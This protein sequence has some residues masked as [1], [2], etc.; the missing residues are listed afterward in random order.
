MQSTW[1]QKTER[2]RRDVNC[3]KTKL[4]A[5]VQDCAL[6]SPQTSPQQGHQQSCI[7]MPQNSI[8]FSGLAVLCLN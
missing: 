1:I 7:T 6:E 3:N 8:C 5:Y 4:W 2:E